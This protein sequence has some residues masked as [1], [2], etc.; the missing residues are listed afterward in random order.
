MGKRYGIKAVVDLH[1]TPGARIVNKGDS[2][3]LNLT[4]QNH[5]YEVFSFLFFFYV[6]ILLKSF[7]FRYGIIFRGDIKD[8]QLFGDMISQMN[9]SKLSLVNLV[10]FS[11]MYVFYFLFFYLLYFYFTYFFLSAI[12]AK[13]S[14]YPP[15]KALFSIIFFLILRTFN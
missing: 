5:F 12:S 10:L 9:L 4:Y 3:L 6:N 11:G 8:I 7:L 1:T 15:R 13:Y 14:R 2:F